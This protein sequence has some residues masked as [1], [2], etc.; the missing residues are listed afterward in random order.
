MSWTQYLDGGGSLAV[1]RH[2]AVFVAWHGRGDS[3]LEGEQGREIFMSV[4]IDGGKTFFSRTGGFKNPPQGVCSCCGMRVYVDPR[5][6]VH[7]LYRGLE[8]TTR[9]M[10]HL[11]STDRGKTFAYR[12]LILGIFRLVP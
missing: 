4:S 12:L 2:G 6:G 10:V 9:P 1:D 8:G 3:K 11:H 5:D 7:M